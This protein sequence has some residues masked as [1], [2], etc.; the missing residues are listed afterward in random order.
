MA[1]TGEPTA[2]QDRLIWELV[3]AG[4][5]AQIAG[6]LK[7]TQLAQ[8]GTTLVAAQGPASEVWLPDDAALRAPLA[9]L[10]GLRYLKKMNA[11][12]A[13]GFFAEALKAPADTLAHRLAAKE[14]ERLKG[15]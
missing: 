8:L 5:S 11:K 1:L 4:F 7:I 13:A 10:F 9:Y 2:D 3:Q 12:E 6:T 15:Q 14:V